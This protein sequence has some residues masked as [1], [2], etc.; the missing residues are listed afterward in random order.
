VL[1]AGVTRW[2]QHWHLDPDR[3]RLPGA[4]LA[5]RHPSGRRLTVTTTGQVAAVHRGATS[6]P[7]GWH[8]PSFQVREP[9]YQIMI[10]NLGNWTTTTF[11][12]G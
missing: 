4:A 3:V 12:V 9:G 2:R 5:F 11:R 6:G 7:Y 8:F 1:E 10:D